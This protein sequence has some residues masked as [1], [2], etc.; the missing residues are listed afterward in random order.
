[1]RKATTTITIRIPVQLKERLE[2]LAQTTAR[3]KSW[4]AADALRTYVE[5]QEWQIREIEAG[6]RAADAGDFA[7]DADVEAVFTKWTDAP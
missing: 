2:Q 5:E 7:A 4:L 3:S 1:M 6:C